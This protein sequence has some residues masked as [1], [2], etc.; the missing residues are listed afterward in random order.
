MG[1]GGVSQTIDLLDEACVVSQ[2]CVDR[3]G[4]GEGSNRVVGVSVN[5]YLRLYRVR[6]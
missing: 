6:S 3:D 2:A 4:T 5:A 1:R